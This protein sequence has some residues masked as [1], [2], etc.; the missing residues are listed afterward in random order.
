[1]RLLAPAGPV[2]QAGTLSGNPVAMAAGLATLDALDA[3]DAWVRLEA[4]GAY[5]QARA[6]EALADFDVTLVRLGSLFWLSFGAG[7]PPRRADRIADDAAARYQ[8]VFRSLL[9]ARILLAPSA[10]EVGFL[11]LAHTEAHIDQLVDA[12]AGALPAAMATRP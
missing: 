9:E 8:G 12:L 7:A 10:Y 3:Q 4:L 1:M 5:L 2:Y 11:S 6:D